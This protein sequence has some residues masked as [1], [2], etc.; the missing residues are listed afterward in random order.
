MIKAFSKAEVAAK[1]VAE[2]VPMD[3]WGFDEPDAYNFLP[4]L[5][6][7]GYVE[8]VQAFVWHVGDY[9]DFKP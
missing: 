4:W 9:C 1:F 2:F 5:V 6:K 3:E 7:N 8:D